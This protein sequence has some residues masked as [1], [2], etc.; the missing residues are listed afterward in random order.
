[1]ELL[2]VIFK[3]KIFNQRK[4][5]NLIEFPSQLIQGAATGLIK[6]VK[7]KS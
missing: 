3:K 5:Y 1:M 7:I 2:I 4:F 6:F